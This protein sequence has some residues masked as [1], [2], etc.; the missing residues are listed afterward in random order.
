MSSESTDPQQS[1]REELDAA[2]QELSALEATLAAIDGELATLAEEQHRYELLE[3][4]C[5]SL[6]KLG[7]LGADAL[8]WG[9]TRDPASTAEPLRRAR[10]RIAD[11][12]S[13]VSSV[14]ERRRDLLGRLQGHTDRVDLLDYDLAE[15]REQEENRK[16]EWVIEREESALPHRAKVMPWARGTEE[17][18]RFRRTLAA[19]MAASLLVAMLLP[20]VDLPV[21]ELAELAEVPERVARLVEREREIPPPAPAV[22]EPLEPEPLKPEPEPVMAEERPEPTPQPVAAAPEPSAAEKVKST[23]ILAFRESFAARAESRPSAQLGAEASLGNTGEASVGRPERAMVTTSAPG[24]SG[25]INLASISRNF[26]D[27][28]GPGL[29]GVEVGQVASSIGA[30]GG[31]DRPLA[32]GHAAGRTDEEIQIVFDRYKSALY[33]LYNR[34]LRRDPTLRGQLVVRLTIE[35]DGTVSMCRLE[36]SDMGAPDLAQQVIERIRGFDFGAKEDVV[37]MTIIYPI[38]FLPAA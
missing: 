7:Q 16:A 1:L 34:E 19:A 20:L 26:G 12:E 29:A 18:S 9:E 35:P 31:A 2:R 25:G 38:D 17:D 30:G 11:F 27:G 14:E 5:E 22:E 13:R 8:F 10:E 4:I 6:E 36:T 21:P 37:A 15:L 33:R 3:R 24:S 23:G 28:G 32:A